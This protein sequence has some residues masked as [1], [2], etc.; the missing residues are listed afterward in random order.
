MPD[1]FLATRVASRFSR[2]VKKAIA[3]FDPK[4][5]K[6]AK[7]NQ[8]EQDW[9]KYRLE[10]TPELLASQTRAKPV[11]LPPPLL[12]K[13]HGIFSKYK[14]L[15]IHNKGTA[16]MK[17]YSVLHASE[18]PT[19]LFKLN[20]PFQNST[21]LQSALPELQFQLSAR[22][23]KGVDRSEGPNEPHHIQK[24]DD[25]LLMLN[26]DQNMVIAY[27][28]RKF[29]ESYNIMNRMLH[30]ISLKYP[31]YKPRSLL[32]FG[33]G[34]SPSGLSFLERFPEAERV[35][36]VEPNTYMRKMGRHLTKD[37]QQFIWAES[38]QETAYLGD[39]QKF[40]ITV[41]SFVLEEVDS[42]AERKRIVEEMLEKTVDGG[43]ALFVL[44][45]S[46][47]GFRFLNDIR[48]MVRAESRDDL[49][50]VAPC[51]H[52]DRCP[53][54]RSTN[55]WCRFEQ[56]WPRIPSDVVPKMP[57]EY[58]RIRSKFCYLI[59]RKGP[60]AFGARDAGLASL[61]WDRIIRPVKRKGRHS[62]I[63]ICN[64]KG[65]VEDRIIAKS[66][67][68]KFGFKESKRLKWGDLWKFPLRISN[69]FRREAHEHNK[70]TEEEAQ[71]KQKMVKQRPKRAPKS[72]LKVD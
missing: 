32:D 29:T 63:T 33:A 12:S 65:Q 9:S 13:F 19:D 39:Q 37:R 20:V 40:D 27:M 60:K 34:L 25:R 5:K 23:E 42:A 52:H 16:Y 10:I 55:N 54:A 49:N 47:M 4:G 30:E 53:L 69:R 71:G 45:G 68:K 2:I 44:P 38:I 62:I 59:V 57:H 36:A 18:K 24:K 3:N 46:P 56:D 26:Y 15:D 70:K 8:P 22:K 31:D 11:P 66:H 28:F 50:I 67:E 64:R 14:R 58:L 1:S 43:F 35:F 7:K 6:Q 48:E 41:C 72:K 61:D 21:D 51:P 17:L